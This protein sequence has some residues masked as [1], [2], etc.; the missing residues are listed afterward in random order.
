MVPP[1]N[2]YRT[3]IKEKVII[4]KIKSSSNLIIFLFVLPA[5]MD[6]THLVLSLLAVI[7]ARL[8]SNPDYQCSMSSE[9]HLQ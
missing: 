1:I 2:F 7:P 5:H 3:R 4:T 8:K 9:I 6:V